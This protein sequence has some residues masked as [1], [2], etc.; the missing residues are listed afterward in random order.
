MLPYREGMKRADGWP[1]CRPNPALRTNMVRAFARARS[2]VVYNDYSLSTA[3]QPHRVK[4]EF[5][6]EVLH[7]GY[8]SFQKHY[9]LNHFYG[10]L[11]G[12]CFARKLSTRQ[13]SIGQ[14]I[15]ERF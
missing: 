9:S 5:Y 14:S 4:R 6:I 13:Q 15:L 3:T 7:L 12:K 8:A 10:L 11:A 2:L 1:Q